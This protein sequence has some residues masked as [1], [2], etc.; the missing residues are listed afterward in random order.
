MIVSLTGIKVM[1]LGV[2][3]GDKPRD[4]PVS[5]FPEI[6]LQWKDLSCIWM[7]PFSELGVPGQTKQRT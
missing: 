4:M 3:L 7:A 5:A 6:Q 2:N 1:C